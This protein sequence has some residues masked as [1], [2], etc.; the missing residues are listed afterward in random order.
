MDVAYEMLLLE[1]R[2]QIHKKA[3]EIIE[4]KHMHDRDKYCQIL[5]HHALKADLCFKALDYSELAGM[6][7]ME[8]NANEEAVRFLTIAL[9]MH[10]KLNLRD[11]IRLENCH[12]KLG[13]AL[14]SLGR[15]RDA[16][17]HLSSAL[18]LCGY[19]IPEGFHLAQSV[20]KMAARHK[21]K[22]ILGIVTGT[23]KGNELASAYRASRM[24]EK[25]AQSA[26]LGGASDLAGYA[27]FKLINLCENVESQRPL[28]TVAYSLCGYTSLIL[29]KND[30]AEKFHQTARSLI[31]TYPNLPKLDMAM[32]KMY[33]AMHAAAHGDWEYAL[34]QLNTSKF[35][36]KTLGERKKWRECTLMV[37]IVLHIQ[38][39][40]DECMK[41]FEKLLKYASE[42]GDAYLHANALFWKSITELN[43]S[44]SSMRIDHQL[45]R[46]GTFFKDSHTD[47]LPLKITKYYNQFHL[48]TD[49]EN[50]AQ[51]DELDSYNEEKSLN[52]TDDRNAHSRSHS[53]QSFIRNEK[54][55]SDRVEA[56]VGRIQKELLTSPNLLWYN[57]YKY[58]HFLELI[59]DSLDE[60][61]DQ[62]KKRKRIRYAEDTLK[63]F[64][65]SYPFPFTK[66]YQRYL[67]GRLEW[68]TGKHKNAF[69]TWLSASNEAANTG[70]PF[71]HALANYHIGR[72]TE[73]PQRSIM[74][75]I[76]K[77]NLMKHHV[78]VKG[79]SQFPALDELENYEEKNSKSID[80]R[81]KGGVRVIPSCEVP[82]PLIRKGDR[83]YQRARRNGQSSRNTTMRGSFEDTEV[84]YTKTRP[85]MPSPPTEK[86]LNAK[87]ISTRNFYTEQNSPSSSTFLN[88]IKGDLNGH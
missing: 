51:V 58:V 64:Q 53:A 40:F 65:R 47:S 4:K 38:C 17:S 26:V 30:L 28:L 88:L 78:Q 23:R 70:L 71:V 49:F 86:G 9:Q 36:F 66:S 18:G 83:E 56:F 45:E 39:E 84:T 80:I 81:S 8:G 57:F 73:G 7:A 52:E 35:L 87:S 19:P 54:K 14:Y 6:I 13:E 42:D 82:L 29:M 34:N 77:K 20:F 2:L 69:R 11:I 1:Q 15:Y 79:H 55:T 22:E 3:L 25:L 63:S 74:L 46:A 60:E 43:V 44:G 68:E 50:S 21:L 24:I 10:E 72:H 85:R 27:A 59:C 32:S 31:M 33:I 75:E 76:A 67:Q 61:D 16:M 48:D 12:V 41:H 5:T 37:G 62:R